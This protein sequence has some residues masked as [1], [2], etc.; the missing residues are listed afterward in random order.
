L[1]PTSFVL[2]KT[3]FVTSG[4]VLKTRD[5]LGFELPGRFLAAKQK[6]GFA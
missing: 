4:S 1:L 3:L 5:S 6:E 2:R